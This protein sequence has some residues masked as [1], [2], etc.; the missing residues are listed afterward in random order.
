MDFDQPTPPKKNN[1]FLPIILSF[2]L[3]LGIWLGYFL[4]KKIT[5]GSGNQDRYHA[6][7]ND[8]IN[9]LLNYIEYQYVDTI[10][11][12]NLVEKTVTAMLQSLDPHS[13]YIAASEFEAVNEPL[14][15]NFDGIGI[16]FNI[17]KD[18]IRVIAPI[19]GGP[20]EKIGIRAGDRLV[21]V[22]DKNVA[23]VKITNKEVFEKL[24][25]KSGTLVKVA[26]A[27]SGVSK[28]LEFNIT[29][30]A[31]PLY[32]VDASYMLEPTIGY[33]KISKFA[34]TTYQEYLKAF[35]A[36]SKKGM[37]KLILDLRGNP[38]G[39][40]NAAVDISDEFLSA[41]Q[42]IVY[43]QGK[44]NPKKVYKATQHGSFENNPLVILIDEGSAS[45]SEIVAG[46][47]Q[48]NDRGTIIG[49]RSFG[50]G[51]VQDQ[52]QLPDGSAIRLTI[53]RYYTPTGR[54]IQKPYSDDK[55]EYYNEEYDRYEHGELLNEDSIKLDKTKQYKTP[56]GKTVYGGGG[57]MPDVFVPLDT[58]RSNPFLNKVF[59]TGVI[60]TF[61]FEYSDN[62]RS[63]LKAYGTSAN[64]INEF[65]ITLSILE[66]F[67]RYCASQKLN[68]DN[69]A[70]RE[71][72]N[73]ALKPY[74]KAFIGRGVFD[75]DAYYPIINKQ[76]KSILKAIDVLSK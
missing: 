64:F 28:L 26:V 75:K 25:G 63:K 17:I 67:Y 59:Y 32:S 40:L 8:K 60:N 69:P 65:Q 27:R 73:E 68:L 4:N 1:V 22:E 10:N 14:E 41:G 46:A 19:T 36:L 49:R 43:T 52:L 2:V 7:T 29:R 35:N 16:E 45:A 34:A 39:Y 9:S 23:G 31:I 76:D 66:E 11:K 51:L 47:V 48:D 70:L 38:G 30:G 21:K 58:T 54:C 50:K 3:V 5:T 71:K 15:G 20:S 13:S 42:Q 33:I 61:A 18:T 74:L 6:G 53:A 62:N 12:K 72:T 24:R 44:A 57:I 37:T 55:D 56:E